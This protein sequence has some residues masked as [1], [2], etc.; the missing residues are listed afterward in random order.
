MA[1][2]VSRIPG[3]FSLSGGCRKS[4]L[5]LLLCLTFVT[6]VCPTSARAHLSPES[7]PPSPLYWYEWKEEAFQQ[8][9]EED[10]LILLDLTA[11]WCHAC[12]VMDQT[13][14]SDPKVI[15]ILQRD[16]IPIRVDTD[17][18]P[19]LDARY[20]SGGW[21]T[22]SILLPTGE[23]LFQANAV[24]PGEM[25]EML[26]QVRGIYLADKQDLIEEASNIWKQVRDRRASQNMPSR[27]P[28]QQS[29]VAQAI[30]M[31]EAE[32]D[33]L[34][35]GFR[36]QPKFFE[37]NAVRFALAYGFLEDRPHMI[38]MGLETLEKQVALLDPVWG[39]FYRYAEMADWSQ[40]HFEKMLSIQAQNLKNYLEAYQLTRNPEYQHVAWQVISY[41]KT[42]LDDPHTGMYFESQDA[43]LRGEQGDTMVEGQ[44]YFAWGWLQRKARGM[45]FIDQRI[46]TGS[47]AQLAEAFLRAGSV[48][49]APELTRRAEHIIRNLMEK[50]FDPRH[51]LAHM[52]LE[53]AP[54]LFGLLTDYLFLGQALLEGYRVSQDPYYLEQARRLAEWCRESLWDPAQGGFFD[55]PRTANALGML[56]MPNKPARE[57]IRAAQFFLELYHLT[58][59]ESYRTVA[60]QTLKSVLYARQPLPISL[61]GLAVDQ[62]FRAPIHIAVVGPPGDSLTEGL[63][64]EGLMIFSPGVIQ[65]KF[66]PEDSSPKWGE[67]TFPYS[68]RPVAF[69]C[70]DRLC[71]PPIFEKE[72]M[73]DQVKE[74]FALM[75][76]K[77]DG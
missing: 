14:Y 44:E 9:Q 41:V 30:T 70:T 13:T 38:Q 1:F 61:V 55:S 57:N 52:D 32:F 10:K 60:E 64:S 43:D 45:P 50:R 66:N 3:S 51:G 7:A 72:R 26:S 53:G 59:H 4:I 58:S 31:M 68:G 2:S 22:T 25:R 16:F 20:R 35:G 74:M 77:S 69:V 73:R 47:N 15:E 75:K 18:R 17:E 33:P 40:P 71:S 28:L 6:G 12:H 36:K 19:D 23:I 76:K 24:E 34:H 11:V 56:Q 54:S 27:G 48:L 49:K 65:R 62:W 63:W 21:P 42:F 29:A 67:I 46:F 37:P 39:G 8:A 5:V